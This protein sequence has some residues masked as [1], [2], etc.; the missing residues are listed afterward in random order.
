MEKN[1]ATHLTLTAAA[2][3]SG[4]SKSII[5]K[6]INTKDL[7]TSNTPIVKGKR[8]A[9]QIDKADFAIWEKEYKN[10]RGRSEPL[11]NEVKEPKRTQ[12][13]DL[14]NIFKIKELELELKF[15]DKEAHH[16]ENQL[17]NV[18]DE[19]E[20]ADLRTNDWKQQAQV[21][22]LAAPT[23]SEAAKP[24]KLHPMFTLLI[25]VIT[26]GIVFAAAT[27][28]NQVYNFIGQQS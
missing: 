19:L 26:F 6:A 23:T 25:A 15:K 11:K 20:K 16:L 7:R 5:S 17:R 28:A 1:Q 18:K 24:N 14:E 2:K 27:Y 12:Q 13:N 8:G 21:L 10:S 22:L 9:Y 4:I 3:Q